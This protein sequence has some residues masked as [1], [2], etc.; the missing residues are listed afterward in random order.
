MGHAPNIRRVAL[1]VA[2]PARVDPAV[3]AVDR[4]SALVQ[5]S[6]VQGPEDLVG[7]DPVRVEL[8]LLEKHRDRSVPQ[9]TVAAAVV[10]SIQKRRKAR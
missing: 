2:S 1:R 9:T 6:A 10:S 8:R 7:H 3:L 5:D 4:D